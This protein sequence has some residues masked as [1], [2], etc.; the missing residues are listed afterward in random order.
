MLPEP[1][2]DALT[3]SNALLSQIMAEIKAK[4]PITFARYMEMAL[5]APQ[6]GYYRN[7]QQKFGRTGDFVTAPEMSPL[8]SYCVAS[9]CLKIF[10]T[11]PASEVKDI[12]EFG[13][14]SGVMAADILIFLKERRA[15]P[16]H[17]FILELSAELK[18]RQREVILSKIPEEIDRVIWLKKLPEAPIVGVVLANE[19]LDAMPVNL[20]Q[21]ENNQL[22]EKQVGYDKKN[23]LYF[24]S[25]KPTI[26]V[27]KNILDY[28][29]SSSPLY[30]YVIEIKRQ[31]PAWINMLSTL[32]KAGS[33]VIIDYGFLQHEYYH[34][35]RHMGTLMCHYRH[36]AHFNPFFYPGLQD[37]TAHVDF[38][39]VGKAAEIGGFSVEFMN[40]ANFLINGGLLDF[41]SAADHPTQVIQQLIS[42][43]EMGELF[44]V[45]LF[46]KN[47]S[48]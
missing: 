39:V 15:L 40:Q 10:N 25:G 6:L 47:L 28:I 27:D 44:K 29:T 16:A 43:N 48:R 9:H 45:M 13:A 23:G 19:V 14:G 46:S 33:V 21:L 22:A 26:A 3:V 17:Y 7:G 8:F 11:L 24:V 38:T 42:P 20:L 35:D 18:S 5:Y 2:S 37:I 41:I 34:P 30:P 4:G 1:S 31:L 32:L 36:Q 12:L